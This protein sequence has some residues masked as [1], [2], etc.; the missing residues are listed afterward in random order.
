M[1][2][3]NT[4]R[5][6]GGIIVSIVI[7]LALLAFL[8]GDFAGNNSVFSSRQNVGEINGSSVSYMEY[9]R[10][11]EYLTQVNKILS[12]SEAISSEEQD[13]IRNVAWE[14]M[15]NNYAIFP[16]Y[17]NLGVDVTEDEMFDL[18]YGNNISPVLE[19]AGFFSNPQTGMYDRARVKN[20]VSNLDSDPSGNLRVLWQYLQEQVRTQTLMSKYLRLIAGMTYVTDVEAEQGAAHANDF[21]NARYVGQ[22]YLSIPDSTVRVTDSEIRRY[23]NEHK[24]YFRQVTSR[25]VEYVVFDVLPSPQDYAEADERMKTLATEFETAE[26]IQQFVTLN[27]QDKFDGVYYGREELPGA[28]GEFVFSADGR[29]GMYGPVLEG[30]V[31]TMARVVD[32]RSLPDTVGLR[33]IILA[34]GSDALADSLT[35]VLKGG[36]DFA[37]TA[38]AYSLNPTNG[39][40]MGRMA[41]GMLPADLAERIYNASRGEIIKLDNPN[42]TIL[43]DVYYRGPERPKARVGKVTYRVEP[44]TATQQ[45]AY[46]KASGFVTTVAGSAENF[47][48]AVTDNAY[49]KRVARVRTTDNS[50]SGLPNSKELIRWAFNGSEGDISS[51]MEVNGN[52]VVALL[53]AIREDGFTPVDQVAGEIAGMVRNEKKADMLAEKMQGASSIDQ[54]AQTLQAQAGE[55]TD[56]NFNAFHIPDM[57]P[58]LTVIGAIC[59][60]AKEGALSKPVKGMTGVYVV[61]V[62]S[63]EK[64][65]ETTPEAVKVRL[66]AMGQSNYMGALQALQ[67]MAEIEDTRI[68]YF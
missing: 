61:E 5:T 25:D 53:T 17:E 20:F 21:Y 64:R 48:K 60:G 19:G 12:G 62:T 18:V 15:I 16:G 7:G 13:G 37:E 38:A 27:S 65:E 24:N 49:S 23:Y 4:L 2:T 9:L 44:S 10:E 56:L 58:D 8:L 11:V 46:A 54:L 43:L 45:A 6:K 51:I 28:L 14:R 52:Y 31:Y 26:D 41:V 35:T 36:A 39:G 68:K 59:G 42:G 67:E 22:T 32:V 3:L 47:D 29:K 30:D 63:T 66:E 33:Q 55:V 34:P 57:G 1:A 40:D 50:I